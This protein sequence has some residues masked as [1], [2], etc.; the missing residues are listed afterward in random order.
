[1][2]WLVKSSSWVPNPI[3]IPKSKTIYHLIKNI[4]SLSNFSQAFTTAPTTNKTNW[5]VISSRRNGGSREPEAGALWSPHLTTEVLDKAIT[6]QDGTEMSSKERF[7]HDK[8]SL[9]RIQKNLNWVK[10]HAR[11]ETWS[12][13]ATSVN[14]WC[15][16]MALTWMIFQQTKVLSYR[17]KARSVN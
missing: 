12:L 4:I 16:N 7:S 9:I 15:M 11:K 17:Q 6:N 2:W 8:P 1:M 3:W 10:G 14:K 13:S 5:Q